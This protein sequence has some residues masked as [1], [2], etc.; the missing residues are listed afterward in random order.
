M[1]NSLAIAAV[2]ATLRNLLNEVAAPLPFDPDPDSDLAD[3]TCSARPP[4]KARQ[5]EDTNQLNL[6]LYQ[7]A[8]NAALRNADAIERTRPGEVGQPVL[9][10]NLFYLLTAY[11]RNFDD[12]LGHRV[13]G[14]AMSIL[15][16]RPLLLPTDIEAALPGSDLGR[17]IERV[18][19]SP[20][21]LGGEELSKL[22]AIFQAPY[23]LTTAYQVS[24]VLIDSTRKTRSSLPVLARTVTVRPDVRPPFPTLE[25]VALPRIGQPSA[26]LGFTPAAITGDT[27]TLAGHDLDGDTATIAFAHRLLP[28]PNTLSIADP[29]AN[30]IDVVLPSDQELWP[31]GTYTVSARVRR[32]SPVQDSTSNAVSV[33]VAP[34]IVGGVPFT[35]PHGAVTISIEVSPKV[36]PAQRVSLFLGNREIS[37]EPHASKTSNLSFKVD[38][39]SAGSYL[40]RLRVDSVDSHVIQYSVTA[41]PAAFDPSQELTVT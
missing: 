40:V 37:A 23:R 34:R 5:S 36:W 28:D 33:V 18:R 12:L 27:V 41:P 31:A 32:A 16:D 29:S 4:D 22:W 17:S 14:R 15:H 20:H 13:L 25:R 10:L 6:F 9:P 21:A 3:T 1:S 11:G 7:T 30:R 8:I 38:D 35:Y 39:L 26:R 2:T 19:I 24:V